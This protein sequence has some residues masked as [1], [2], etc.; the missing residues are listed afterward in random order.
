MIDRKIIVNE[1][2]DM[3]KPIYSVVETRSNGFFKC[4]LEAVDYA[5]R[6]AQAQG[7]VVVAPQVT[8]AMPRQQVLAV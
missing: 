2:E 1:Y 6:L 4:P 5:N 7:D 3:G 8:M